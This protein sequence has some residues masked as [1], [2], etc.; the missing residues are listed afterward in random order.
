M[1]Y[2]ARKR[3]NR[4]VCLLRV[5]NLQVR[6]PFKR[7]GGI[8]E[9][10]QEGKFYIISLSNLPTQLCAAVLFFPPLNRSTYPNNVIVL[11][12]RPINALI[13]ISEASPSLQ[14]TEAHTSLA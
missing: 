10:G 6:L 14:A 5:V 9:V 8:V 3:Q 11:K 1:G 12:L 7:Q 4:Y 13:I 2:A